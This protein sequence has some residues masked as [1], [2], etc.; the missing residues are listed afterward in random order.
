MASIIKCRSLDAAASVDN[1]VVV[2]SEGLFSNW[3]TLKSLV[4]K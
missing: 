2:T 3:Y 4:A 1:E